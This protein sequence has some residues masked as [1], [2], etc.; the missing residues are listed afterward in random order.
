MIIGSIWVCAV[1]AELQTLPVVEVV[2]QPIDVLATGAVGSRQTSFAAYRT[3]HTYAVAG[4]VA[5]QTSR[6]AGVIAG[7]E[8]TAGATQT[9]Q[10]SAAPASIATAVAGNAGRIT[11]LCVEKDRSGHDATTGVQVQPGA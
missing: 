3:S 9:I 2:G 4:I 7:L 5:S 1:R 11:G 10:S 8:R 6:N